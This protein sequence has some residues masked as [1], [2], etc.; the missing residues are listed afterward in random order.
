MSDRTKMTSGDVATTASVPVLH[1]Q[2]SSLINSPTNPRKHFAEGPMRELA[3]N[4][5]ALA[6]RSL[7]NGTQELGVQQPLFVRPPVEGVAEII[8]G[9]RRWRA[10][11]L[12]M[13]LVQ[14]DADAPQV[15]ERLMSMPVLVKSWSDE[16]VIE[17]QLIENLRREDL[18][19]LEEA[20]GYHEMVKRGYTA[21]QIAAKVGT[22]LSDVYRALKWCR[23]PLLAR[24]PFER[25]QVGKDLAVL[26]ARIPG[27]LDRRRA[28]LVLLHEC[29]E[30]EVKE[31]NEAQIKGMEDHCDDEVR[32]LSVKEARKVIAEEFLSTLDGASFALDDA[33]LMIEQQDEAGERTGGGACFGCPFRVADNPLLS[34]MITDGA[35][36]ARTGNLCTNPSCKAEKV[37]LQWEKDRRE[38]ESKGVK[39]LTEAEAKKIFN[40]YHG[41]TV[42]LAYGSDYV[43][44]NEKPGYDLLG[45]ANATKVKPW[46]SLL[47]D[48]PTPVEV[49]LAQDGSGRTR[50][51]VKREAAV[52]AVNEKFAAK[53]KESPL[54]AAKDQRVDDDHYKQQ[55]KKEAEEKK[56]KQRGYSLALASLVKC[57]RA[58][59]LDAWRM[60][61]RMTLHHAGMD[62]L[63]AL[64]AGLGLRPEPVKKGDVLSQGHYA[65]LIIEQYVDTGTVST[66]PFVVTAAV[67]AANAWQGLDS[68]SLKEACG[69]F[70]VNLTEAKAMAR[71]EVKAKKTGKGKAKS[72]PA[73][74]VNDG[75]L[76][77]SAVSGAGL[78]QVYD[79]DAETEA[80][81]QKCRDFRNEFPRGTVIQFAYEV[82]IDKNEAIGIWHEVCDEDEEGHY[83]CDG[84]G[85]V[86]LVPGRNKAAVEKMV[87]GSFKGNCCDSRSRFGHFADEI[88]AEYETWVP[89]EKGK[90][91]SLI[92]A[93]AKKALKKVIKPAAKNAGKKK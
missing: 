91:P 66:L 68:Q 92:T 60:L 72:E 85:K 6:R 20:D 83:H 27:E 69:Q 82:E 43:D 93:A 34:D 54:A 29:D 13:E 61:A 71:D 58:F 3:E 19:P 8:S 62:G 50:K 55:Q 63:R 77:G 16:E 80:L 78:E 37:G 75:M 33:E 67:V 46:E 89:G 1:M 26:I 49:V 42:S 64:S 5:V 45:H 24:V 70:G 25:G 53:G 28:T 51:L 18:T 65:K 39:V 87:P 81:K 59:G 79:A 35:G 84:C 15:I 14:N 56:L 21:E 32:P 44:L 23:L 73:P 22:N 86:C 30:W 4:I 90:Q 17:F 7:A 76:S 10:S 88:Q 47:K 9:E 38:A 40:P 12:A 52:M 11:E 57:E 48:S 41:G 74:M 2:H 36:G 31:A